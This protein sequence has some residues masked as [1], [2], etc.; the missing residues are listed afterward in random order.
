MHMYTASASTVL[1]LHTACNG[2]HTDSTL[3]CIFVSA[4]VCTCA[5]VLSAELGCA[6]AAPDRRHARRHC[7]SVH[8]V[9]RP[10]LGACA[11]IAT[12]QLLTDSCVTQCSLSTQSINTAVA[13]CMPC[14]SQDVLLGISLCALPCSAYLM[15]CFTVQAQPTCCADLKAVSC[16]AYRS[17]TDVCD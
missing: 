16:A 6:L 8:A 9:Q 3:L 13:L 12:A 2:R 15:C 11:C 7:Q 10:N 17:C 1:S 5:A 4:A 14:S